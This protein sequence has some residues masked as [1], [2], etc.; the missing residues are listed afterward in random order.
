M[1]TVNLSD[2]KKIILPKREVKVLIGSNSPVS[3]DH[4]TFGVCTVSP[5]IKMDPHTHSNE[6]E[7][8]YILSGKGYVEIDETKE[9]IEN[10]TVIKIPI[11]SASCTFSRHGTIL[12]SHRSEKWENTTNEFTDWQTIACRF[13]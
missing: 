11:G 13:C 5:G 9:N 1:N 3:S 10:G 6:E 2:V 4:M 7:I 12:M 8:I